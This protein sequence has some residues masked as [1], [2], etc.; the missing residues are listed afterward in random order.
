MVEFHQASAAYARQPEKSAPKW[1]RWKN[2]RKRGEGKRETG[3]GGAV[4]DQKRLHRFH[5]LH[6]VRCWRT[7]TLR[8]V[9]RTIPLIIECRCVF[10]WIPICLMPYYPIRPLALAS[11]FCA[12]LDLR[13]NI[14]IDIFCFVY[15]S[16]LW[17]ANVREQIYTHAHTH[18]AVV[19]GIRAFASHILNRNMLNKMYSEFETAAQLCAQCCS[20]KQLK[21]K[22]KRIKPSIHLYLLLSIAALIKIPSIE[23]IWTVKWVVE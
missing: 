13:G 18:T 15:F 7:H 3:G 22:G 14:A 16:H 6:M 5:S 19:H 9:K 10:E 1:S 17:R 20:A 2:T 21:T 12:V 11:G 8:P 4:G 23:A